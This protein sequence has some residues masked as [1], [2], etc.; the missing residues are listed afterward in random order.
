MD[1]FDIGNTIK[2]N[3]SITESC[4]HIIVI[5]TWSLHMKVL[6][7]SGFPSTVYNI[8]TNS[9]CFILFKNASLYLYGI[10]SY[11]VGI[12]VFSLFRD[13]TLLPRHQGEQGLLLSYEAVPFQFNTILMVDIDSNRWLWSTIK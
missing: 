9:I 11:K 1:I 13:K 5:E 12:H 6:K 4:N 7:Y 3:C 2:M 10:V 8:I